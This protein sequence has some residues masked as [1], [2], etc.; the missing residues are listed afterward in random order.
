MSKAPPLLP[1]RLSVII[2]PSIRPS[3]AW[4]DNAPPLTTALL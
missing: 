4:T 1:A 3:F 2:Q